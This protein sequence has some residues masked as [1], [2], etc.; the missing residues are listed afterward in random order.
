MLKISLNNG[1][2]DTVTVRRIPTT[3]R[4]L[5]TTSLTHNPIFQMDETGFAQVLFSHNQASQPIQQVSTV[6]ESQITFINGHFKILLLHFLFPTY[7][8][9]RVLK[10]VNCKNQRELLEVANI[11]PFITIHGKGPWF[12]LSLLFWWNKLN[13]R[14]LRKPH[15]YQGMYYPYSMKKIW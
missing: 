8:P 10:S 15:F 13:S 6:T 9:S 2:E 4:A 11:F 14:T 12:C 5:T 1:R 3:S 7:L